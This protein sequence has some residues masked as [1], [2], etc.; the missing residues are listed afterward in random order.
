MRAQAI[1]T[2]G[3]ILTALSLTIGT[4]AARGDVIQAA[5]S[6][7]FHIGFLRNG[8]AVQRELAQVGNMFSLHAAAQAGTVGPNFSHLPNAQ[9]AGA[10]NTF[11]TKFDFVQFGGSSSKKAVPNRNPLPSGVTYAQTAKV[12]DNVARQSGLASAE[13]ANRAFQS[14]AEAA[15]TLTKDDKT[16]TSTTKGTKTSVT[17]G[18]RLGRAGAL[19]LDPL[20]FLG[21]LDGDV[22]DTVFS[23]EKSDFLFEVDDPIGLAGSVTEE[24]SNLPGLS[25]GALGL[26]ESG[27]PILYR[28][29]MTFS[30][31]SNDPFVTFTG[32]RDHIGFFIP[33]TS[34]ELSD[35]QIVARVLSNVQRMPGTNTWTLKDDLDVFELRAL[36]QA[37]AADLQVDF[38]HGLIVTAVPLPSGFLLVAL[39]AGVV[40]VARAGSRP[41]PAPGAAAKDR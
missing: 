18:D 1:A 24:A 5:H 29:T 34:V 31:D 33:G 3:C 21:V 8:E 7:R 11:P 28:L 16:V 40:A 27:N 23:L 13:T 10:A 39:G 36:L 6:D 38:A 26:S 20:H 37:D 25:P 30:Q 41:K 32:Q 2:I 17:A 12:F 4:G 14:S 35:N 15:L 22:L 19:V 9:P